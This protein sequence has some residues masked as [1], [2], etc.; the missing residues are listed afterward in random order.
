MNKIKDFLNKAIKWTNKYDNLPPDIKVYFD[1][2]EITKGDKEQLK[3]LGFRCEKSNDN[4]YYIVT[5]K[6]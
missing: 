3:H 6:D 5:V 4:K 2:D 1:T